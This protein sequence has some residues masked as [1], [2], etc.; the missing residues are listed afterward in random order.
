MGLES[1]LCNWCFQANVEYHVMHIYSAKHTCALCT[2]CYDLGKHMLPENEAADMPPE[3]LAVWRQKLKQHRD[4]INNQIDVL[5]AD[6]E[7]DEDEEEESQ[8]ESEDDA[9]MSENE[10]EVE[11]EAATD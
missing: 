9:E 5:A 4:A 7:S 3:F 8:E 11:N 6:L 2:T 10:E 1:Y